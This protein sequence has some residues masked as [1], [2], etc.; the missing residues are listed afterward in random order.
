MER[1]LMNCYRGA[2]T[3]RRTFGI[4][5]FFLTESIITHVLQRSTVFTTSEHVRSPALHHIPPLGLQFGLEVT[6]RM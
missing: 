5:P 3:E 1:M 6:L 4:V 2:P